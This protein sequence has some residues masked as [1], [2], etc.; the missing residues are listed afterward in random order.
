MLYYHISLNKHTCLK[1]TPPDF[2]LCLAKSQELPNRSESYFYYLKV[3]VFR[4]KYSEVHQYQTRMKVR[5]LPWHLTRLFDEIWCKFV[6]HSK[7][8]KLVFHWFSVESELFL[9]W[10]DYDMERP[11]SVLK[12]VPQQQVIAAEPWWFHIGSIIGWS[13]WFTFREM[14]ERAGDV[15]GQVARAGDVTLPSTCHRH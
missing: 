13:L 2:W 8:K 5:F 11:G 9:V 12:S 15:H 6:I 3:K 4:S 14:F 1:I 10:T 7:R